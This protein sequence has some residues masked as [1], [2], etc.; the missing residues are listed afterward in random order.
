MAH[1]TSPLHLYLR[2]EDSIA[3]FVR[4]STG[5]RNN[6]GSILVLLEVAPHL[7]LGYPSAPP[8]LLYFSV[9]LGDAG[10]T[11]SSFEICE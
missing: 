11:T 10:N 5:I 1:D 7:T 8:L 2:F 9:V 3:L 6:V 4:D